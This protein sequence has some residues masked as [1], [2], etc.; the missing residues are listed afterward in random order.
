MTE[1]EARLDSLVQNKMVYVLPCDNMHCG[2]WKW[3]RWRAWRPRAL[4]AQLNC[5]IFE[6]A[7]RHIDI[8]QAYGILFSEL[9]LGSGPNA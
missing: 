6:R 7:F 5:L 3:S 9:P 2:T 4:Q 8:L 1:T